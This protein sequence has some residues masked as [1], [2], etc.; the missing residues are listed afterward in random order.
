MHKPCPPPD[1]DPRTPLLAVPA[2][3]C[4]CHFHIFGP[5]ARFFYAARRSYTPPDASVE[6]YRRVMAALGLQR[7]VIVQP[8]VYGT[9]NTCTLDAMARLGPDCRGVAVIDE[10]V[11]DTALY[12]MHQAGIRGVRFNVLYKGGVKISA[13]SAVAE[14]IAP[15]GW[16]I[17]FLLDGRGL[18]DLADDLGRLPVPIVID[19]LGHAPAEIGVGHPGNQALL[20]LVGEGGCWVKLSAAYRLSRRA[21]GYEDTAPLARALIEAAPERVVW[22]SDWPHPS[23]EGA[24]PNDGDLLDLLGVWTDDATVRH[25]ILVDNPAVLYGF[26]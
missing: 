17:Q 22:G 12:D 7:C 1:P 18:A 26:P 24:M 2:G 19:H 9:D 25:K 23:V 14:R 10:T 6:D 15:L 11:S 13:V 8:S 3:A 4:D 5:A 21:P 16:H 20:A